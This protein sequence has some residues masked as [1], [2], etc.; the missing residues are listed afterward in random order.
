MTT[1]RILSSVAF[2]GLDNEEDIFGR[3]EIERQ[4][5]QSFNAIAYSR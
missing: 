1:R 4:I 2:V 5:H 3:E